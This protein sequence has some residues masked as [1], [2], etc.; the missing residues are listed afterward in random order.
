MTERYNIDGTTF[1]MYD[2]GGQRNERK[3]WIHCFEGT[4]LL[5]LFTE[6]AISYYTSIFLF[7]HLNFVFDF[8]FIFFF[9]FLLYPDAFALFSVLISYFYFNVYIF[10]FLIIFIFFVKIS[11]CDGKILSKKHK[12]IT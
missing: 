12:K 8:H 11:F 10:S 1:E 5:I 3:K 6:K 9:C 4:Y 7:L 2:V